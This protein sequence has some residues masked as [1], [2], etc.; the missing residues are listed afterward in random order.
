VRLQDVMLVIG[1]VYDWED[2]LV[3]FRERSSAALDSKPEAL[4]GVQCGRRRLWARK[5][6]KVENLRCGRLNQLIHISSY[7]CDCNAEKKTRIC[8]M[9]TSLYSRQLVANSAD[10]CRKGLSVMSLV[11][12][13]QPAS[14]FDNSSILHCLNCQPRHIILIVLFLWGR[15]GMALVVQSKRCGDRPPDNTPIPP[16]STSPH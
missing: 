8:N 15:E 14:Y 9:K 3:C 12:G 11:L 4:Q 16:H 5:L 1:Y 7:Y 13:V 10:Q 6:L 2:Q